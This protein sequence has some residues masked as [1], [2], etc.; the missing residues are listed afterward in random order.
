MY[1]PEWQSEHKKNHSMLADYESIKQDFNASNS[2]YL[3]ANNPIVSTAAVNEM[4]TGLGGIFNQIQPG[5]KP[6]TK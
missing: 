3:M 4:K 1:R 5:Q 2:N 6:G